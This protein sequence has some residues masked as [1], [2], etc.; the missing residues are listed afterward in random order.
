MAMPPPPFN[1]LSDAAN[2]VCHIDQQCLAY[3]VASQEQLLKDT[4]VA[5]MLTAS[6][7]L[8]YCCQPV[9]NLQR[10]LAVYAKLAAEGFY[11][12][13]PAHRID[14]AATIVGA[15]E[16]TQPF[17][18]MDAFTSNPVQRHLPVS[19]DV[20]PC[21]VGPFEA[22]RQQ[23]P[24]AAMPANFPLS[25]AE[26]QRL[27]GQP[28]A[29]EIF[30]FVARQNVFLSDNTGKHGLFGEGTEPTVAGVSLTATTD[31]LPTFLSSSDGLFTTAAF[32]YTVTSSSHVLHSMDSTG[33]L[34]SCSATT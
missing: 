19:A 1:C 11:A 12:A 18:L 25:S 24:A 21:I 2:G 7:N 32:P 8:L 30:P 33:K 26:L 16:Q 29:C 23:L 15:H 31:M 10:D 14:S 6:S 4:A 3:G 22:P 28:S 27:W 13:A 20:T 34:A 5:T 9:N 17:A